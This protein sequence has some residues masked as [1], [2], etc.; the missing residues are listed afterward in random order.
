MGVWLSTPPAVS[1]S[2]GDRVD[3]TLL[4]KR[5]IVD[6]AKVELKSDAQAS[7][8]GDLVSRI[9]TRRSA[10][11]VDRRSQ[12]IA[13]GLLI[14]RGQIGGGKF[15][16]KILPAYVDLSPTRMSA[17]S[18]VLNV[19][20]SAY[21]SVA[22]DECYACQKTWGELVPG[23]G[24][25]VRKRKTRSIDVPQLGHCVSEPQRRRIQLIRDACPGD[26][27]GP[28]RARVEDSGGA[29]VIADDRATGI[30]STRAPGRRA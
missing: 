14:N 13:Q 6:I 5:D 19:W 28:D 8:D 24:F 23:A 11:V 2:G 12:G 10:H 17:I 15:A 22:V 7:G 30:G 21:F 16:E 25:I 4:A 3:E 29:R 20:R 1:S 18:N 26:V 9:G 27:L